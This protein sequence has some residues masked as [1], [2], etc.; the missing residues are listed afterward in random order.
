MD[1]EARLRQRNVA[2]GPDLTLQREALLALLPA[3]AQDPRVLSLEMHG[4]LVRGEGDAG[5]DID[6]MVEVEPDRWSEFWAERHRWAGLAGDVILSLDHQWNDVTREFYHA[7][8]LSNRVYVDLGF[9]RG[10][11]SLGPGMIRLWQRPGPEV[12]VAPAPAPLECCIDR[13]EDTF[14]IFW[15]GASLGVK[16]LLRGDLWNALEFMS[17]RRDLL[18]RAWRLVHYPEHADWGWHTARKDLPEWMQGRLATAVPRFDPGEMAAALLVTADLMAEVGPEL[19]RLGGVSYPAVGAA[20][21]HGWVRETAEG[22]RR[23]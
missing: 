9:R 23:E 14:A 5:S 13:L 18:L 20:A 3:L 21:I 10:Q 12:P 8:I 17:S 6:L 15:A 4:S 22:F 7:A 16:Y 19:A 1:W 2:Q 11:A